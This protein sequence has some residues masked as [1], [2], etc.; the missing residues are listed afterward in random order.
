MKSMSRVKLVTALAFMSLSGI[1]LA[2]DVSEQERTSWT[3]YSFDSS[4]ST[5]QAVP[6]YSSEFDSSVMNSEAL[7]IGIEDGSEG[8]WKF[9]LDLNQSQEALFAEEQYQLNA[10][11]SPDTDNSTFY[12]NY[13]NRRV[14]V[15][16]K[17]D[18]FLDYNRAGAEGSLLGLG[19]EQNVNDSWAVSI[20]Y[21]KSELQKVD[22]D[23]GI[24]DFG[25]SSLINQQYWFDLNKDGLPEA[26]SLFSDLGVSPGYDSATD[27]I[28]IRLTRQ[29][30]DKI[31]LGSSLY[32][33]ETSADWEPLQLNEFE[34]VA[35]EL[36]KSGI[37]LFSQIDFSPEWSVETQINHRD[38]EQQ[39]PQIVSLVSEPAN[40]LDFDSTTLD[41]GVEYQGRWQDMGLVI[42]ID[43][44]N[45]LGSGLDSDLRQDFS[46]DGLAPYIFETPKYI[47][48]SG[49]INF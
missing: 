38:Y 9:S 27:G 40:T 14:P 28:E 8:F 32:Q 34:A 1:A 30:S 48:L 12:I 4:L 11:Y 43:L 36:K 10:S 47:K 17:V 29:V 7:S 33:S 16:I 42:R 26:V 19:F 3:P 13:G 23:S 2:K 39:S 35:S 21:T 22:S 15:S 37:S 24:L 5:S 45:L 25:N 49:S 44:V 31:S 6:L 46:N 41:I 18:E 20:S